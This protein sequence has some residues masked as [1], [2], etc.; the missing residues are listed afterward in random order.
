MPTYL[1]CLLTAPTDESRDV[2]RGLTGVAGEQVR[3]LDGGGITA[4]VGTVS[5]GGISRT[6][7]TARAH[8][9]VVRGAFDRGVTLL[10]ARS[11][12]VFPSDA[13][14][15]DDLERRRLELCAAL[16]RVAGCV[17][18][19]VH[20][21]LATQPVPAGA[22][23][24]VRETHR[25]RAYL[26]RIRDNLRLERDLQAEAASAG[27]AIRDELGELVRGEAT[28]L[29]PGARPRGTIAH[30][31]AREDVERYRETVDARRAMDGSRILHIAGPYPPYSFTRLGDG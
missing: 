14:C 3:R 16:D 6:V 1:Y 17:E 24:S 9:R 19:T 18:M 11:G 28:T 25:G 10:P 21:A 23:R 31:I 12:Q 27:A 29:L 7:E 8:D 4:W 22:A 26:A 15:I 30:L 20:V 5:P 2:P 13:H